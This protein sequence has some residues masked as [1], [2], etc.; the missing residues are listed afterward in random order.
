M[1]RPR[2]IACILLAFGM[3]GAWGALAGLIGFPF[4]AGAA[5]ALLAGLASHGLFVFLDGAD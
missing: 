2:C 4:W 3:G 5:L 1:R